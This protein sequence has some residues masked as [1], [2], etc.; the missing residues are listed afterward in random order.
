MRAF[1]RQL[2]VAAPLMMLL[3]LCA[4]RPFPT[5]GT[6]LGIAPMCTAISGGCAESWGMAEAS[7]ASYSGPLFQ[8]NNGSSTLN[9]GQTTNGK[10]DMTT[11][12][13]FC[14]GTNTTVNGIVTNSNCKVS[15]IY[16]EVHGTANNLVPSV[17]LGSGINCT[18]GGLTCA[19]KFR[20]EVATGLPILYENTET[21]ICQ[22]TLA[23]DAPAVGIS[24]GTNALSVITNGLPNTTDI[25]CCGFFGMYHAYN[26]GDTMWTDFGLGL[27]YGQDPPVGFSCT[28]STAT[29]FGIDEEAAG[30]GSDYTVPS[31]GPNLVSVI[32][33]EA[34]G[35]ANVYGWLNGNLILSANQPSLDPGTSVHL[36]GG[37]DLSQPSMAAVREMGLTNTSLSQ[38]TVNAILNQVEINFAGLLQFGNACGFIQPAVAVANGL[39]TST[40][41][42]SF[43]SSATIDG[44]NT[45]SPGYNWYTG[46]VGQSGPVQWITPSDWSVAS[47]VLSL[48]TEAVAGGFAFMSA[49]TTQVTP[50]VTTVGKTYTPPF[51]IEYTIAVNQSLAPGTQ[52]QGFCNGVSENTVSWPTIWLNDVNLTGAQF[53]GGSISANKAEIDVMEFYVGCP[54]GMGSGVWNTLSNI[55]I[56]NTPTT[57]LT[58]STNSVTWGS[59][60]WNGTTYHTVGELVTASNAYTYFDGTLEQTIPLTGSFSVAGTDNYILLMNP[61]ITWPLKVGYVQVWQ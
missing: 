30:I 38:A 45:F 51:Y 41:C 22:Y 28:T 20:Y 54:S 13:A 57:I 34:V 53:S 8:L 40:L 6:A 10:A 25:Q 5:G 15:I 46:A 43:I 52:I 37:G 7:S 27:G 48:N 44:S 59:G 9:I 11:W 35:T 61:G 33:K 17:F 26:A 18:A 24:S 21:E 39:N 60:T 58:S 4:A 29:C 50:T 12:A 1:I 42:E 14:G 3:L 19:C 31:P 56:W 2:L 49:T 47:N 36:G 16:A 23:G 32:S 55:H